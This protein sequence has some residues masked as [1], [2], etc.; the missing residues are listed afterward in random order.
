MISRFK[1]WL[2]RCECLVRRTT[3]RAISVRGTVRRALR[4]CLGGGGPLACRWRLGLLQELQ[5]LIVP[6]YG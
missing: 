5:T 6:V 2:E 4:Y 3:H 1:F